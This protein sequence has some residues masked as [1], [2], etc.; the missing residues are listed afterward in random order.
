MLVQHLVKW[1]LLK[2]FTAHVPVPHL[3][4]NLLNTHCSVLKPPL[5]KK[6]NTR[7]LYSA[8]LCKLTFKALRMA[9]VNEGSHSFTCHKHVYPRTEWT[10]LLLIP[11]RSASLQFGRY[12][13]FVPRRVG[14]WVGLSGWL[15]TEMVY[16]PKDGHTSQYQATTTRSHTA[17]GR[18]LLLACQRGTHCQNVYVTPSL[19]LLFLAVF[20]KPS[21]Y[22]CTSVLSTLEAL[23]VMRY[24]NL[25]FTYITHDHWVTSPTP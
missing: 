12:S 23:V 5:K 21:F 13:F 16:P 17:V 15:H 2:Q 18:S 10:I 20:S 9:R 4:G 24:I 8:F 7:H 19:V 14:G 25:R 3:L 22:Q 6:L 1:I 11:S